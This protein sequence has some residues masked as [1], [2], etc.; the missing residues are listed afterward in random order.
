MFSYT[1]N[2]KYKPLVGLAVIVLDGI[3]GPDGPF[4][5]WAMTRYSYSLF[6]VTFVSSYSGSETGVL[7]S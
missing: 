4:L 7:L 5:L 3:E 2:N 1:T 6:A